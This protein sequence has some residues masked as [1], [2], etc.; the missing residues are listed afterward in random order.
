MRWAG[1]V[2]GMGKRIGAYRVLVGESEEKGP[3]LKPSRRWENNT[4]MD[5]QEVGWGM[6]WS[7]CE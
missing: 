5:L 3:L 6:D 2:A 7:G 4:E 1:H